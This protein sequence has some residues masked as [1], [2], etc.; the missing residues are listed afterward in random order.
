M[1][2]PSWLLADREL[3][4]LR[5]LEQLQADGAADA[6]VHV[7]ETDDDREILPGLVQDATEREYVEPFRNN[8]R[9]SDAVPPVRLTNA[10]ARYVDE[11][12]TVRSQRTDRRQACR[13]AVLLLIDD[14]DYPMNTG[15]LTNSEFRYFGDKFSEEEIVAACDY[16]KS[17]TMIEG[18]TLASG[19]VQHA[20]LTATGT[21]CVEAFD[22]DTAAFDRYSAPGGS[23]TTHNTIN[24]HGDFTGGQ[25]AQGSSQVTMTS[26]VSFADVQPLL[27]QLRDA[28]STLPSESDRLVLDQQVDDLVREVEAGT[29][30]PSR[31]EAMRRLATVARD[32]ALVAA[33]GDGYEFILRLLEQLFGKLF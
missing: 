14:A 10:G 17:A 13:T 28:V 27:E 32:G 11:I 3:Q 22:A 25:V 21:R 9:L 15:L 16:L 18:S 23:T 33:T 19:I 31:L 26:G 1:T 29:V 5:L 24:V 8:M 4:L 30:K 7:T 12:N 2:R 6:P 20:R